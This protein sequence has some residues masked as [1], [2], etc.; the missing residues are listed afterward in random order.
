MGSNL[1]HGN[2]VIGQAGGPT[3]V[4][5]QSLVGVIEGLRAEGA[6]TPGGTIKKI[7]GMRFGVE[8]LVKDELFDLSKLPYEFMRQLAVTPSAALGSTRVKPDEPCCERILASC[9][10]HNIRYFFYIGGNDTAETCRIVNELARDTGYDMRCFHVPKTVDND[11]AVGD[12]TPGFPSAAR[13][14]AKAC[15]ADFLDNAALPGIKINVI[16]GRHAGYL[17]AATALARR[18]HLG[19]TRIDGPQ[20]I[21]VP[22]IPFVADRF[23]QDVAK[24]FDETGRCHI[25][26]SEGIEDGEGTPIAARLMQQMGTDQ[27]GNVQLSGTGLLADE[28]SR[29]LKEKLAPVGGKP[30]RVR[31][32]TFGYLQRCFPDPAP[33]DSREARAVGR[34]AAEL[35]T[36]G[37]T[38]GSIAIVRRSPIADGALYSSE[39]IRVE[40][41][42]VARKARR[43]PMAFLDGHNNVSQQF[44]YY[45]R[46]LIGDIQ[47][48]ERLQWS[49]RKQ[50][51]TGEI[52][53]D[54]G[55]PESPDAL[56]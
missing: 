41:A 51:E 52:W 11:L 8:G 34:K 50:L 17:T 14:V 22:E 9:K 4:I 19:T 29:L 44:L 13:F 36:M 31:A 6:G 23:V 7:Y 28:L 18:W 10:K 33:V 27:H 21:Y 49:R 3:T 35:A 32:D 12:H 38:D 47:R 42:E 39:L 37:Q 55:Q 26:V 20:L 40:L 45:C 24:V 1:I 25:A 46:P 16:M 56:D 54:E 15:M 53:H 43:M 48:F 2:A 5:N 30:P